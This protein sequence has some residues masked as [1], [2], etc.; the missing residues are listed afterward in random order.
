MVW[1]LATGLGSLPVAAQETPN[2][3]TPIE[4]PP[5]YC[6][7]L[8]LLDDSPVLA[9]PYSWPEGDVI[10]CGAYPAND[11]VIWLSFAV[12]ATPSDAAYALERQFALGSIYP[13]IRDANVYRA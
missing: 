11:P 6:Q 12:L 3:P 7:V 13:G 10:L 4:P 9:W 8:D 1:L 5:L 2:E